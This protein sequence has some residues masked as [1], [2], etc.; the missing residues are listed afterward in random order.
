[1]LEPFDIN[2]S[3]PGMTTH[4][5]ASGVTT[6]AVNLINYGSQHSQTVANPVHN[7]QT[8]Q[9]GQ[10]NQN[11]QMSH[12]VFAQNGNHGSIQNNNKSHQ[13]ITRNTSQVS[14]SSRHS[15]AGTTNTNIYGIPQVQPTP[16]TTI[17]NPILNQQPSNKLSSHLQNAGQFS[18]NNQP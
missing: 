18:S 9:N 12:N 17:P 2:F 10:T 11:Q 4:S 8:N 13:A 15:Y 7:N 14:Q 5:N 6:N 16:N 3:R 1:M